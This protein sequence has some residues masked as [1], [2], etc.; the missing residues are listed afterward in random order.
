[1]S[2]PV[3]SRSESAWHNES[4]VS[5]S[6]LWLGLLLAPL[7]WVGGELLGYY[8]TARACDAPG[9]VP[10]PHTSHPGAAVLTI[11]IVAAIVAAIGLTIAMRSWRETRSDAGGPKPAA[12]GRARFMAFTGSIT[13]ALFLMGI[14]W[15]GFPAIVVNACNQAR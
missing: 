9:G 10:F 14:V 3:T 4:S 8:V 5:L 12:V 2:A 15:F 6:R 11:E 7:A 13:S 1:M